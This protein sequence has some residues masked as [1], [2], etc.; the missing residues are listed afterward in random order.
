M[1]HSSAPANPIQKTNSDATGQGERPVGLLSKPVAKLFYKMTSK[2]KVLY[3][4]VCSQY[5]QSGRLAR[6]LKFLNVIQ[7]ITFFLGRL[8]AQSVQHVPSCFQTM[9]MRNF[10]SFHPT[11]F[12]SI[13]FCRYK[14][15][16]YPNIRLY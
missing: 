6:N 4:L 15:I 9:S 11:V 16:V 14:I 13:R 8:N 1:V 10:H 7:G 5:G 3:Y 2:L 12:L